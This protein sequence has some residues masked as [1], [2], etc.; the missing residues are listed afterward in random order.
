MITTS[1]HKTPTNFGT[2][3]VCRRYETPKWMS[4]ENEIERWNE[5]ERKAPREERMSSEKRD[6]KKGIIIY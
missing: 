4:T 2:F 6:R 1:K 3:H 5:K